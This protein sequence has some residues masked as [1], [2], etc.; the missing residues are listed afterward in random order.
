M[1][2]NIKLYIA[3]T[4]VDFTTDPKILYNYQV[5]DL[6]NPTAVKNSFS[7][8]ITIEGSPTN[9]NIFGHYWD[10]D[11]YILNSGQGSAYFN[12]SKKVPFQLFV[13]SDLYEEG[14]VK[15]DN[16]K[17]NGA[18]IEYQ[19]TLYGGVGDFFYSLS[20]TDAGD[21]MKLSDL[22]YTEGGDS[23]EFDFKVNIDTV[24]EA[25]DSLANETQNKWQ[26]INF[27][28]AYNGLPKDF[29]SNKVLIN[30][31]GTS[32]PSTVVS[33]GTAYRVK[34]DGWTIA[35]LPE[36]MTEWETRDLRSYNQ[37]PCIRMRSIVEACCNPSNNGGWNINL[38]PDF[39]SDDNPYWNDTWLTL[40]KITD[41]EYSNTQQILEGAT[42]VTSTTTG[43]TS[44]L[45]Y[46][47]LD[48]DLGDFPENLREINLKAKIKYSNGW[49]NSSF[50]WFWNYNGDSYHSGW[51]CYGS[52]FCQLI[53]VNGDTVVGASEVYNL[54]TPV[55]HNGNLYFGHNGRYPYNE[56][57]MQNGSQ[58]VP[59][60]NM[61]IYNVL[62]TFRYDGFRR[63]NETSGYTF[64]FNINNL[65]GQ[66]EKLRMVFY[67]GASEDKVKHYTVTTMFSKTYD[68]AWVA[69]EVNSQGGGSSA[70]LAA[71]FDADSLNLQAVM[72]ES[73]GRT[74]TQVNKALLLNTES[75]PC[76]YLL[77]YCKMFGLHF[78]KEIGSKTIN[79][80]TRKSFYDRT[81]LI[82]L[83]DYIDFSKEMTITPL[84][85]SSKW[86][87]FKQNRDDSQYQKAYLTAKGVDYGCKILDTGYE[88][89]ADKKDL[90]EKNA[91]KAGIEGEEKSKWY[92]MYSNDF[93]ARPWMY[94]G[95]TY[96]TW[97]NGGTGD[98]TYEYSPTAASQTVF[99]INENFDSKYYDII[100]KL[101]F[102]SEGNNPTEGNNC[103]VFFSGVKDL[104]DG[105][106][107]P[108]EYTLSDDTGA[109][110]QLND[111]KPCWLF[112]GYEIVN[113]KRVCYQLDSLPVFERYLTASASGNI[114]KSLDFGSAQELYIP[115]YSLTD[116]TNIY[117]YFWRT[118][119]DDLFDTNT[120]QLTC[121]VKIDNRPGVDWLNKFF[122][123]QNGIWRINKISDWNPVSE[124]TTKVEFIKVQDRANYTSVSQHLSKYIEVSASTQFLDYTGGTV[125]LYVTADENVPWRMRVTATGM[126]SQVI[127]GTGTTST[128]VTIDENTEPTI[129]RVIVNTE[130][131]DN[132]FTR[133]LQLIQG[134][135]GPSNYSVIPEYTL[136]PASGGT[137]NVEFVWD[138][139]GSTERILDDVCYHYDEQDYPYMWFDWD[140]DSDNNRAT[141]TVT[142]NT[143]SNVLI[144][145]AGFDSTSN[146][147]HDLQMDQ[148]PAKF[149]FAA[150]GETQ[151]VRA[152]FAYSYGQ[153]FANVPSWI[154]TPLN[155]EQ[156]ELVAAANPYSYPRSAV[157]T[158][159]AGGTAADFE[160]IQA[161][162]QMVYPDALTY[163]ADGGDKSVIVSFSGNWDIVAK[164]NWI[165]SV[166]SGTGIS[167]VVLTASMNGGNLR[168][169]TVVFR[170]MLNNQTYNV[171][172]TQARRESGDYLD[173]SVSDIHFDS[174]G[175]T[176]TITID[177]NKDWNIS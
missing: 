78:T 21:K 97:N 165:T 85:F 26:Y 128:T 141:I 50:V 3:D 91:I 103:L 175:G 4:E 83:E 33:G 82:D 43:S 65:G 36:N 114:L 30:V 163:S 10:L 23:T 88:F 2:G 89:N 70:D 54:T 138:N 17:R 166:S 77:S 55:R 67:W 111:G 48:F 112:T 124:S 35:T 61:P 101:Q 44:G 40:P 151:L 137:I 68:D 159:M 167:T 14:Y 15:L 121:Y 106:Q 29:D 160:V 58:Y 66:V 93:Q 52:L 8:T 71:D 150:S 131:L 59:F 95:M 12:S 37:R 56:G 76:D 86:Y 60:M 90:L 155:G 123:F 127:S 63:E 94:L 20:T 139:P 38:D 1:V 171:A 57:K 115:N 46:E 102:H 122:Y 168:T 31:N 7:R 158:M 96:T 135:N 157:M 9:N 126:T 64:N 28:P 170:N 177:T 148:M 99:A 109:Q 113:G 164:P 104:T 136:L 129:R 42:L 92:V 152:W 156:Y 120:R 117:H 51:A 161:G 13:G 22:T 162:S 34:T 105:R 144:N 98:T 87:Q 145:F 25:W 72:G 6:K 27:M 146:Y 74:G 172:V 84:L 174:T 173:V 80:L 142:A 154:T 75:T 45:M 110:S 147:M 108:I 81:S 73:L 133:G 125:T 16:I 53:A 79:I 24:K 116:D 32:L 49:S 69:M 62:G 143:E 119:M 134:F 140:I 5:T 100:P 18:K 47:D 132:G 39:F 107:N 19:C 118:Y 130:R 176:T 169:G 41:L 11:R 153:S 149:T